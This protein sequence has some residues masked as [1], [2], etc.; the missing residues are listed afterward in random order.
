MRAISS[1]LVKPME[2]RYANTKK[3][4]DKELVLNTSLEDHKFVS[5]NAIVYSTPLAFPVEAQVG[6][7]AIIH[8]NIFRRYYDVKGNEKNSGSYITEDLYSCNIDQLFLYKRDGK[9]HA[10]NEYCFVKP[11]TRRHSALI[12]DEKEE[13][14]IGILKY[15]NS[16]L[17]KLGFSRG[18]LVGF[19]PNSE[20]EFVIEGERLYRVTTKSIIIKYEYKGN[21]VEYNPGWTGSSGGTNQSS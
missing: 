15:D 9:W 14:L 2:N 3:V 1:Y 8:H 17:N 13:S 11:I 18:D 19:T 7:E 16:V 4:G 21:E 5:R 12:T 10:P 6:D 20:Y